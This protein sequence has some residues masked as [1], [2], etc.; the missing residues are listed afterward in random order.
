MKKISIVLII[1]IAVLY[2]SIAMATNFQSVPTQAFGL[3]W[4]MYIDDVKD[5]RGIEKV[6]EVKEFTLYVDKSFTEGEMI[7]AVGVIYT[8]MS[9]HLASVAIKMDSV[10]D[11]MVYAKIFTILYGKPDSMDTDSGVIQWE[12]TGNVLIIDVRL[13]IISLGNGAIMDRLEKTL[14]STEKNRQ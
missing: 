14:S 4:G 8:F 5:K 6:F 1:A 7:G 3:H 13:K 9:N 10:E 11:I 12:S 2:S